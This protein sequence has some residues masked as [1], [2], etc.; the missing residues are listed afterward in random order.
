MI[1]FSN[2]FCTPF[3]FL[4]SISLHFLC[5]RNIYFSST[6]IHISPEHTH[7]YFAILSRLHPTLKQKTVLQLQPI[8]PNSTVSRPPYI[9]DI[10]KKNITQ[11]S[12]IA[13]L[14]FL[15][16]IN[17]IKTKK[18]TFEQYSRL[19]FDGPKIAI[20]EMRSNV[21]FVL[22]S[23]FTTKDQYFRAAIQEAITAFNNMLQDFVGYTQKLEVY[24]PHTH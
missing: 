1:Q 9:L 23:S 8:F 3:D 21:V 17:N 15:Y 4:L 20:C 12:L 7:F 18:I 22:N 2:I 13:F 24:D 19:H 11:K 14:K 16:I 10:N 6:S 5:Y